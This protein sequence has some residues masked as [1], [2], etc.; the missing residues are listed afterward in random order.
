MK[1]KQSAYHFMLAN[2]GYSHAPD[3]A[4]IVGRRR[5]AKALAKA[6]KRAWD[7]GY[8][9]D[10]D[11]DKCGTSADWGEPDAYSVWTCV[12]RD[13]EGR[14]A[15]SLGGIDMGRGGEP[16]GNPYRRVVEAELACDALDC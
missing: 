5:C 14:I 12:M 6:E 10:W 8:S 2:A 13:P 15:A 16:W 11:I 7:E 9:F 1:T 3:E 4:P